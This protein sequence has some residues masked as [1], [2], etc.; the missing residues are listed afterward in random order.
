MIKL[1][2]ENSAAIMLAAQEIMDS[3]QLWVT[4]DGEEI[5]IPELIKELSKQVSDIY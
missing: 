4:L 3:G 2:T 1:N 5:Y